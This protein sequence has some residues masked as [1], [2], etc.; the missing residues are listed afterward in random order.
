MASYLLVLAQIRPEPVQNAALGIRR[1]QVDPVPPAQAQ[2]RP[3]GWPK[4]SSVYCGLLWSI[5]V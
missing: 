3:D 2:A 5:V 1:E 4:G